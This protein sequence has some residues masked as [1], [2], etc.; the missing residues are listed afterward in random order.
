MLLN[1]TALHRKEKAKQKKK[2]EQ[3]ESF[4]EDEVFDGET[5]VILVSSEYQ[6]QSAKTVE[7]KTNKKNKT[8]E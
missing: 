7:R 2:F 4:S 6:D 1:E 5:P 8:V 3:T